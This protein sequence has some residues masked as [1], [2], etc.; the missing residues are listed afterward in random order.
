[1]DTLG[2]FEYWLPRG[3]AVFGHYTLYA[4][5]H[6]TGRQVFN[7]VR[8]TNESI[9]PHLFRETV[10]SDVIKSDP[11]IIGAFKVQRRLDLEDFKTGF[12]YLRR[13]AADIITREQKQ[14]EKIDKIS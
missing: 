13:Y 2:N 9:W 5:K 10:G 1:M 14:S 8:A 3:K 6:L 11:T 12:N 7:I 4:N